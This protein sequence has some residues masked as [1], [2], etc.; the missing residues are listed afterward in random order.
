M[1]WISLSTSL[2]SCHSVI[3]FSIFCVSVVSMAEFDSSDEKFEPTEE[4][5]GG[6]FVCLE[7]ADRVTVLTLF[8]NRNVANEFCSCR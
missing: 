6:K 5:R 2:F 1:R 3:T 4:G 7:R 8:K